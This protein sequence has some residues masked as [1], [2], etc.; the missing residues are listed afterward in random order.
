MAILHAFNIRQ[1]NI[2]MIQSAKL[3]N[4]FHTR[5]R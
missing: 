4:I 2:S 1:K 3:I 5:R